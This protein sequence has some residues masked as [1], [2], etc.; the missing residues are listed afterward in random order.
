MYDDTD[1]CLEIVALIT[2]VNGDKSQAVPL[3]MAHPVFYRCEWPMHVT[4]TAMKSTMS[5]SPRPNV[6]VT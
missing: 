3:I 4:A 1:F 2:R 6:Y 5:I